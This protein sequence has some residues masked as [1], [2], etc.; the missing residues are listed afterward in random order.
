MNI[1]GRA[2]LY[3]SF[4]ISVI[5]WG[6]PILM[7]LQIVL[8]ICLKVLGS[9]PTSF[10][11]AHDGDF[12]GLQELVGKTSRD[13]EHLRYFFSFQQAGTL[14]LVGGLLVVTVHNFLPRKEIDKVI[15]SKY[16]LEKLLHSC[17][18]PGVSRVEKVVNRLQSALVI[19]PHQLSASRTFE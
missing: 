19:H 12:V 16:H 10:P 7:A 17:G 14:E 2:Y 9:D 13:I 11:H 18:L 15:L 5:K 1:L 8:D 4:R 6:A 3:R